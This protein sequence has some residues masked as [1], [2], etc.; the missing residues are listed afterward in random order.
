MAYSV[1]TKGEK[2][3]L[4]NQIKTF[5]KIYNK[6]IRIAT[7]LDPSRLAG[8]FFQGSD[9]FNALFEVQY[10]TGE[11]DKVRGN[12]IKKYYISKDTPFEEGKI[13]EYNGNGTYNVLLKDAKNKK[14]RTLLKNV[15]NEKIK[16]I[17][18]PETTLLRKG[19]R[20]NV[21]NRGKDVKV[22]A[23]ILS[24]IPTNVLISIVKKN[25]KQ[26]QN[27]K[28]VY[29]EEYGNWLGYTEKPPTIDKEEINNLY[30]TMRMLSL[31]RR[32]FTILPLSTGLDKDVLYVD[33]LYFYKNW[34]TYDVFNSRFFEKNA[35]EFLEIDDILK[36]TFINNMYYFQKDR[37]IHPYTLMIKNLSH[38]QNLYLYGDNFD[39]IGSSNI[40]KIQRPFERR[41]SLEPENNNL[42]II[43]NKNMT[44]YKIDA[45]NVKKLKFDN[46]FINVK[47]IFY[48]KNTLSVNKKLYERLT[49]NHSD[50]FKRNGIFK[51]VYDTKNDYILHNNAVNTIIQSLLKETEMSANA[52]SV[53][54]FPTDKTG[55][56]VDK[57]K[58]PKL[59]NCLAVVHVPYKKS[60]HIYLDVKT[61]CIT[62]RHYI[63]VNYDDKLKDSKKKTLTIRNADLEKGTEVLNVDEIGW[64]KRYDDKGKLYR[65]EDN[66]LNKLNEEN[67]KTSELKP[68]A[69]HVSGM[70]LAIKLDPEQRKI[71][72]FI[73]NGKETVNMSDYY[74]EDW[75]N[76]V[77]K[78]PGVTYL[79]G[80][81]ANEASQELFKVKEEN[82]VWTTK[83]PDLIDPLYEGPIDAEF[84]LSKRRFTI[85]KS[86][87]EM[88]ANAGSVKK[89]DTDE[90]GEFVDKA[91][92]PGLVGCLAVV[93]VPNKKDV[94]VKESNDVYLDVKTKDGEI[95][96]HWKF[97]Y[98]DDTFD[99]PNIKNLIIT[100]GKT[101][102]KILDFYKVESIH[103]YGDD[104]K[105]YELTKKKL[106][107]LNEEDDDTDD[108]YDYLVDKPQAWH[109]AGMDLDIKDPKRRNVF[110]FSPSTVEMA[111]DR[112]DWWSKMVERNPGVTYLCGPNPNE[113][114]QELLKVEKENVVWT[115]KGPVDVEFDLSERKFTVEKSKMSADNGSYLSRRPPGGEP[116][117]RLERN[118]GNARRFIDNTLAVGNVVNLSYGVRR[119]RLRN[120]RVIGITGTHIQ[121]RGPNDNGTISTRNIR[122]DWVYFIALSDT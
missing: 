84:D 67:Y 113:R 120:Q 36:T 70:D 108:D 93:H 80:P 110:M 15:D 11:S 16:K 105:L 109:V 95:Y 66:E 35:L 63:F 103:R 74:F 62:Y 104:G 3:K 92:F 71:F 4:M 32:R 91:K 111:D 114:A 8:G 34:D 20:V 6:K 17:K 115:G 79:C 87:E 61:D 5:L 51:R 18:N 41:Y 30:D 47:E 23:E 106:K 25:V 68:K 21:Y 121:V 72:S 48:V 101:D 27:V 100:K 19:S 122:K 60:N 78:N 55:Y 38:I 119:I 49:T 12:R 89:F 22:E 116:D 82:V 53:E 46:F 69:W 45:T 2:D 24:K 98:L 52:G 102:M 13:T 96:K 26:L 99:D 28:F 7:V 64:I 83:R 58:F 57:A 65:V 14:D 76:F 90:Y 42:D 50:I 112:F 81:N 107:E 59:E 77:E 118:R 86:K 88:S 85:K 31:T 9:I 43:R 39:I 33:Q 97:Y 117:F 1:A 73:D 29:F 40:S 75:S 54:E 37:H 56:F 94:V 44:I 10:D